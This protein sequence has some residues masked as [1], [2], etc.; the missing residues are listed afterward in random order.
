MSKQ[1]P[2]VAA[3]KRAFVA[4]FTMRANVRN[5]SGSLRPCLFFSVPHLAAQD[6][7]D[8][9]LL[10]RIGAWLE[11]NGFYQCHDYHCQ[12]LLSLPSGWTCWKGGCEVLVEYH[13]T[14][15]QG[16]RN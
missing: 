3:L 13:P 10:V 1:A 11:S 8:R 5:A 15:V 14:L 16:G 2:H 12:G 9:V 4:K 6:H 7:P